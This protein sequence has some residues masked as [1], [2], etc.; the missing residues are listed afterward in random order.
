M[1][2][3]PMPSTKLLLNQK[4]LRNRNGLLVHRLGSNWQQ[5]PRYFGRDPPLRLRHRLRVHIQSNARICVAQL[6]LQRLDA[7]SGRLHPG[8]I[9]VSERVPPDSRNLRPLTRRMQDSIA[10]VLRVKRSLDFRTK[11]QIVRLKM[12]WAQTRQGLEHDRREK[13]LAT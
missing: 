13:D 9:G 1:G 3:N 12:R 8:R 2:S 10:D 5:N 7:F 11:K 6:C 4:S